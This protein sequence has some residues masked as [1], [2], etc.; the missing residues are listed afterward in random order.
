MCAESTVT[1]PGTT[2]E[3]AEAIVAALARAMKNVSFYQVTHPVVEGILADI[4]VELDLLLEGSRSSLS[5]SRT[6]TS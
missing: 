2:R 3:A 4:V 6:A 5:S 1:A